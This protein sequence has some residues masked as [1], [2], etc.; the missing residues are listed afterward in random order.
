MGLPSSV[1]ITNTSTAPDSAVEMEFN[2][3]RLVPVCASAPTTPTYANLCTTSDPYRVLILRGPG[4]GSA[5]CT[6]IDFSISQPGV[7]GV[8]VFGPSANFHLVGGQQ[9]IINFTVNVVGTPSVDADPGAPGLQIRT[10]AAIKGF[11]LPPGPP[12]VLAEGSGAGVRTV[13]PR[14]APPPPTTSALLNFPGGCAKK[15]AKISVT[16]TGINKVKF[17]V[18]GKLRGVDPTPPYTARMR[19]SSLSFGSHRVKAVVHFVAASG[20]ATQTLT[21][22]IVRCRRSKPK[23]TN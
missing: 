15:R 16:G 6:G 21:G 19:T 23:F 9:C 1:T 3:L 18:N 4:V 14:D 5:D 10:I 7:G 17:L 20:R 8:I 11:R 13:L 2:P 12:I 22:R